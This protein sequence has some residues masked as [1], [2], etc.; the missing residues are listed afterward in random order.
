MPATME[1][2]GRAFD[3]YA[4]YWVTAVR[5]RVRTWQ[6]A[7]DM[8]GDGVATAAANIGNCKADDVESVGAWVFG[9]IRNALRQY[10][11]TRRRQAKE[12]ATGYVEELT[13]YQLR[14]LKTEA[15]ADDGFALRLALL[16]ASSYDRQVIELIIEGYTLAEISALYGVTTS[17]IF[18]RMSKVLASA[19]RRAA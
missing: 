8:V 2:L 17:A 16:R 1:T 9:F 14:Q 10:W 4:G 6:D 3:K 19:K 18:A 12:R 5:P 13:P 7:E 15:Q 11:D